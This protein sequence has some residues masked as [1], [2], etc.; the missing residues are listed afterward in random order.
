MPSDPTTPTPPA[1]RRARPD[2]SKRAARRSAEIHEAAMRLFSEKGY[3]ETSAKDIGDEVG[4]L[5]ASLYY[6]ITSKEELLYEILLQLHTVAI[7]EMHAND[8]RGGD[9][10]VRL[11]RLVRHHVINHDIPR[12]R[13]FATEFRHLTGERHDQIVAMRRKYRVYLIDLIKEAQSEGL[14]DPWVNADATG[15][16]LLGMLNSMPSWFNPDRRISREEMADAI[17]RMVLTGLGAKIGEP[18][19]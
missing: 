18:V 2:G 13:L 7:G 16:A 12:N 10:L 6:H 5:G 14:C 4:L 17:D 11:R 19:D 9:A 3:S 1:R 15:I 8:A